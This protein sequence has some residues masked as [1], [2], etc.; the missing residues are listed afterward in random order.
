MK[1]LI[2]A[3]TSTVYYYM[4]HRMVLQDAKPTQTNVKAF[5]L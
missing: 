5:D 3:L 2:W 1:I 4:P